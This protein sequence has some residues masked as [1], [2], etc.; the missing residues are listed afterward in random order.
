VESEYRRVL[1]GGNVF[2]DYY[3]Y[4]SGQ[5]ISCKGKMHTGRGSMF[6]MRSRWVAPFVAMAMVLC[7]CSSSPPPT[8]VSPP[9][10]TSV[11]MSETAVQE[12]VSNAA[13]FSAY[14][15]GACKPGLCVILYDFAPS[16]T[17]ANGVVMEITCT[18]GTSACATTASDWSSPTTVISISGSSISIG[19]GVSILPDGSLSAAYGVIPA[20]GSHQ[21]HWNRST[22]W[23]TWASDTN[24][25]IS[26]CRSG[27]YTSDH[28]TVLN[29]GTWALPF[30]CNYTSTEFGVGVLFSTNSGA[31][32]GNPAFLYTGPVMFTEIA[33]GYLPDNATLMALIRVN[34]DTNRYTY[35]STDGGSNGQTWTTPTVTGIPTWGNYPAW[36]Y[37][38]TS[39]DIVE[40]NRTST[41]DGYYRGYPTLVLNT[42]SSPACSGIT[43]DTSEVNLLG[44]SN[45]GQQEYGAFIPIAPGEFIYSFGFAAYAT[46]QTNSAIDIT[47][48][49]EGV[50]FPGTP[51]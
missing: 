33:M 44:A 7:G 43:W 30:Y 14:P 48:I 50:S 45:Y 26:Q 38:P 40:S 9:P 39:K 42:Y 24:I 19:G 8:S 15:S 4:N 18:A 31:S 10:P 28:V 13:G 23:T 22:D 21:L 32:W 20:S 11:S 25:P 3:L 37:F 51:E 12:I 36:V 34:T 35:C 29:N 47:P 41:I 1:R 17:L 2:G 49:A 6:C 46:A 5:Q 27:P 16:N